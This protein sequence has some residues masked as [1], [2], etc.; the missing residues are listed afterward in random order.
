LQWASAFATQAFAP[1]TESQPSQQKSVCETPRWVTA[2]SVSFE[3]RVS[4]GAKRGSTESGRS[5]SA[6]G[7]EVAGPGE[8]ADDG[9]V[10]AGAV[11]A[12]AAPGG[13]LAAVEVGAASVGGVA[14]GGVPQARTPASPAQPRT[15]SAPTE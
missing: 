3:Q 12:V 9:E 4:R 7:A 10:V 13:S 15:R 8:V 2:Q 5:G 6:T 14:S 11:V 1:A